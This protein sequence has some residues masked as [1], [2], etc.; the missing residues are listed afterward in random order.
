[1]QTEL[2]RP[3]VLEL[4]APAPSSVGLLDEVL[5][6]TAEPGVGVLDGILD[7]ASKPKT[8]TFACCP[9]GVRDCGAYRG[10]RLPCEAD[11]TDGDRYGRNVRF[12]GGDPL[13]AAQSQ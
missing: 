1:M 13:A 9:C 12:V 8:Q 7:A 4:D 6:R 3:L 10:Q 2:S 5:Y 11:F